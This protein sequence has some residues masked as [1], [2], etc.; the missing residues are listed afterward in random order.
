MDPRVV[1]IQK[2]SV[3]IN[4]EYLTKEV[5]STYRKKEVS[6]ALHPDGHQIVLQKGD[7]A[8][9][10]IQNGFGSRKDAEAAGWSFR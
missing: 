1:T 3:M 9:L 7:L 4:D 2:E 5:K 10:L 8:R 6:V